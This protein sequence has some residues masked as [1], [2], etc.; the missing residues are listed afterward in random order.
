M[1]S[2]KP[3]KQT[4]GYHY[5]VGMH[6][7]LCHGP[8]DGVKQIWVGEKC[9]WPNA[10]NNSEMAADGTTLAS[11]DEPELLGGEEKEGGVVGDV[12]IAYGRSNQSKNS[13]LVSQLDPTNER[14]PAFRGLVGVILKCVR[15]GTSPYL[16]QW[17]FVAKRTDILSDGST[18]WLAA[19]ADIS[20]DMNPAHIIRECLTN[21]QWGL[22]YS[23]GYIDDTTFTAAAN[24]LY[25]ENFGLSFLWDNN[26]TVED[27]INEI[28]RHIDG[29]LYQD[30]GTGKFVLKL[31]RDDYD[32][33]DLEEFSGE[34]AIVEVLDFQRGA[35]GEIPN[36]IIVK[37][38]DIP[39]DKDATATAQDIAMIDLQGG[40]IIESEIKYPGIT[41]ASLANKVAARDLR[42]ATS[43]LARMTVIG[44]RAMAHLQRNDVFLLTWP[45]LGISQLPVRIMQVNYG[46]LTEG[47][48]RFEV[49]EDV[50]KAS[51]ALYSDPPDTSWIDPISAP[52]A[53]PA[54]VLFE[55][56][57][58]SIVRGYG[59]SYANA[60]DP[61]SGF[62]GVGAM[63]PSSDALD[64][65]L[66]VR[67]GTTLGFT[68]EGRGDFT[69]TATLSA[70][71]LK[72]AA[73]ATIALTGA[74]DLDLVEAN[75]YALIGNEIV[76]VKTVDTANNQ[77]TIARGVLDTVPAAHAEGDRIWFIDTEGFFVEREYADNEQP[78][79]KIL[80]A[81][82]K[83]QLAAGDA[84]AYNA[85]VMN[86][87]QARPYPP[88]N[89]KINDVSYPSTFSGQPTISWSHR[90][91]KQQT[92]SIIEHSASNIG[93]EAGTTY[94]LKIYG[95]GGS[96][97]RTVTD[98]AGTS[99][100]YAEVDE[101]AD[102]GSNLNASLR[103]ELWSVRDGLDS[104]Q[105]YDITVTRS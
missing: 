48:I 58:Y 53:A 25:S 60:L 62:M 14:I 1:P 73:D 76:L 91:R 5:S 93:P 45:I 83:G 26:T 38:S 11:I 88:G 72:N 64:Y 20:G 29:V 82:G 28:L 18:Q 9:A 57:Y 103:F 33:E 39:K 75:T 40:A 77:I 17:S 19:K 34:D 86:S 7:L 87:R 50:F 10:D 23:T 2:S 47:E 105:K 3:K 99:Y 49:V 66:L 31:A 97:K 67:D 92:V 61:D 21:A 32:L 16:K 56:P 80:P 22:G 104:W 96:L 84:I 44:N 15:V 8:I 55:I 101:R 36:Q 46:S 78:G 12:D 68:S 24:K 52:Q 65:E 79:V 37:Y 6:M 35:Y 70:A 59:S 100:T 89:V 95:D 81:T 27:F 98:L 94:T 85:D 30:I 42:Q 51:T 102:N 63:K 74:G 54:R 13:Y 4:V 90:D 71:L 41:K 69:P 43:M